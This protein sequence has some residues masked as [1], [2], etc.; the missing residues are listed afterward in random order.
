VTLKSI[1]RGMLENDLILGTWAKANLQKL[2][3]PELAQYEKLLAQ[4]WSP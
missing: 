4:V 1:E 2:Q 3:D